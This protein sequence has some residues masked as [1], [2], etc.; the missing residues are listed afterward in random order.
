MLALVGSGE[1][2]PPMNSIDNDLISRLS[3]PARVVCLPT[4]AGTEGLERI[5][6]WS[7]LGIDHF[8]GLGARV[9][10][11]PVIDQ[12]TANDETLAKTVA[13]ANFIYLSGG[14]PDYLYNTLKDSLV[15]QA[16]LAVVDRGG[17]LAGCSAGAMI[18]GETFFGFPGWKVAFGFLPGVTIIPHYDEIPQIMLKSI[19]RLIKKEMII[20]GVERYTAL[21]KDGER[22]E[23]VGTGGVTIWSNTH[24]VRYTQG[25]LPTTLLTKG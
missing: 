5:A 17:V 1:Y 16:I 22:Y 23:V 20:V 4:A 14:K 13:A 10:A 3:E 2:L 11:V 15:W 25:L 21:V 12:V 8:R 18:M 19:R 7:T 24:K 6:Y 9:E